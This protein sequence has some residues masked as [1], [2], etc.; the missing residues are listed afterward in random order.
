MPMAA[1]GLW[2]LPCAMQL[3]VWLSS[4]TERGSA[5]Q[6]CRCQRSSS[7]SADQDPVEEASARTMRP[8][9]YPCAQK[10]EETRL[11]EPTADS[12]PLANDFLCSLLGGFAV[13]L[14]KGKRAMPGPCLPWLPCQGHIQ[15][16]PVY[17]ATAR[18]PTC[19]PSLLP[20]LPLEVPT[21]SFAP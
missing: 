5:G 4:S 19:M 17:S 8:V 2:S 18:G 9:F 13:A 15:S 16:L 7:C 14:S 21:S 1:Q 3:L 20:F 10:N 12:V 6:S 11:G